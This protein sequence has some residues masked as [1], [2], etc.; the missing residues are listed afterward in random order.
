M[1]P[2]EKTAAWLNEVLPAPYTTRLWRHHDHADAHLVLVVDLSGQM[3]R[4]P[5]FDDHVVCVLGVHEEPRDR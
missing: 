2:A 5:M 3:E 1:T 4:L